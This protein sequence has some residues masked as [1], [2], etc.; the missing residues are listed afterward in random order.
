M[1]K[2]RDLTA[3]V[4]ELRHGQTKAERV[5]WLRLKNKQLDGVKFHPHPSPLPSRE[6]GFVPLFP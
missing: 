1:R 5:L 6:R 3:F 4:Q 2:S